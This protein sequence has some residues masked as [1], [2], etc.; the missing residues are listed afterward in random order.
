M[1]DPLETMDSIVFQIQ[2]GRNK[3]QPISKR[4]ENLR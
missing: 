4:I 2:D 1:A 3:F